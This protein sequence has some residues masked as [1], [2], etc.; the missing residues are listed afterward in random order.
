MTGRNP[1][2]VLG[3]AEDTPV[4]EVQRAFRRRVKQTHPDVGG[5][6][7]E[8]ASVVQAF[9]SIRN[10]LPARP[11]RVRGQ[12]TAYDKWIQPTRPTGLWAYDVEHAP[13]LRDTDEF[14][15]ILGREVSIARAVAA[16]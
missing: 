8:L 3:V 16:R 15:T 7:S 5:D 4:D 13:L 9:D 6:A 2:A 11:R 12:A 10:D 1:W 14:S